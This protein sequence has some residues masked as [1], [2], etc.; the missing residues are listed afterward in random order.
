MQDTAPEYATLREALIGEAEK[1]DVLS[2]NPDAA[3]AKAADSDPGLWPTSNEFEFTFD[4]INYVAQRFRYPYNNV[5]AVLYCVKGGKEATVYL[6]RSGASRG[7][8]MWPV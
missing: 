1:H 7:A 8:A 6:V 5:V 2:V 3:L 4:G